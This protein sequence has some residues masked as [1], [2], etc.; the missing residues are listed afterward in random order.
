MN[1][2]K[3][4]KDQGDKRKWFSGSKNRKWILAGSL[5]LVAVIGFSVHAFAGG[6]KSDIVYT[7]AA[8]SKQDIRSYY[9]F[10]GVI[11]S[12][13]E[14]IVY[15]SGLM[16]VE[17]LSVAVGD[18]V[19]KGDL[20]VTYEQ[21]DSSSLLQAKTSV[22]SANLQ[23]QTAK[24]N[25]ERIRA[26]YEKDGV[27]LQEYESAQSSYQ[28]AQL[29]LTQAQASYQQAA[30]KLENYTIYAEMDGM[31]AS[32]SAKD[33]ETLTSG[34]EVLEIISY[35]DLQI[36]ITIDEYDIANLKEGQEA[37]ITVNSTGE[38]FSGLISE[39]S[40]KASTSNGVSYF[41]GTVAIQNPSES[42]S[43][44]TSAEVTITISEAEDALTVPSGAVQY[45]KETGYYVLVKDGKDSV[46]TNVEIGMSNGTLTEIT[47]GIEEGTIV[48]V[49][50][51]ER[52]SGSDESS[53][54]ASAGANMQGGRMPQ[55][56]G[57]AGGGMPSG[58]RGGMPSGGGPTGF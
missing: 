7:E 57:M 22:S 19:K 20:L 16:T 49:P 34:S 11:S 37:A 38:Q 6:R 10:D 8:A 40:R 14:Q 29:Q 21:D 13:T 17:H 54:N 33:G 15:T 46:K 50:S 30:E 56:G 2:L 23:L 4:I 48:M 25:L 1:V 41:S 12:G 44:G 39:L 58:D 24:N 28:T 31:V 3:K 42:I 32:V 47:K 5:V 9:S 18:S 51:Y 53:Q 55:Q 35:D 45:D 43:V 36:E 52:D 27:S 26:L